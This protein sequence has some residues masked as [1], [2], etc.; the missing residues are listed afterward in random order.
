[1]SLRQKTVSGLL[2]SFL[3][4]LARGGILFVSGI[5]LARL[6]TP[7]EF[8]LI[9]MTTVF[10][11]VSQ[12]IINS[13][14]N[15]ALIR[16]QDC[17]P[18]DYSTVFYFN[19]LASIVLYLL[20]FGAAGSVAR[21]FHEPQLVSILRVLGLGLL[22]GA[23]GMVQQTQIIKEIGFK[24]LTRISLVSAAAAGLLG[25]ALAYAGYGVWS[26]VGMTLA[27][28]AIELVL[29]WLWR[30]WRPSLVFRGTSFREMFAFGSRL[31]ASGL[32]ATL[33]THIVSLVI[34]RFF[35]AVALGY[36]TQAQT[37]RN[38]PSQRLTDI[39]QRVSYP[40]L[41][42]LQE[43][44]ARLKA[45]YRRMLQSSMLVTFVLMLGMSACAESLVIT[46]VGE[47]WR[48]AVGYL[49]LLCL[50]GVFYPLHAINLNMFQ[51]R[52]RS[53]LNLKLSV[54]KAVLVT[55][56]LAIGIFQG[57][58]AM[59]I[60]MLFVSFAGYVLTATWSSSLIGYRVTEQLRDTL[61]ALALAASMAAAVYLLG[62]VLPLAPPLKLAA[63]IG[64]GAAWTFGL[65]ELTRMDSYLY[66]KE[67]ALEKLSGGGRAPA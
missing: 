36:Y 11:A 59:I 20:L 53:D 39:V 32:I 7:R 60:A 6:L 63:Q 62:R 48:P 24:L 19:L 51:V 5:L 21:F 2:W 61:P 3:D 34:G 14:F 64:L 30:T 13:G 43:E 49:R 1:M 31:L 56:A 38:L 33:Q 9:G 58:P 18:A 28:A 67:L 12:S 35:S 42:T 4:D 10:I 66:L 45:A 55:P 37:F 47:P 54:I 25:I 41:A 17:T 52:G 26:L 57:I 46:L 8:G 27:R 50:A 23:L 15:Q 65:A 22:I 16:K 29:L 40:V 44:T